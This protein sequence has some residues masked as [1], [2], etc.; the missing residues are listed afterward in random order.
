MTLSTQYRE[1]SAVREGASMGI[2]G[3]SHEGAKWK[4]ITIAE[5]RDYRDGSLLRRVEDHGNILVYGGASVLWEAFIG[6]GSTSTGSA[7]HFF[8]SKCALGIGNSSAAAVNTQKALQGGSKIFKIMSAGFPTHTTGST[9]AAAAQVQF[10]STFTTAQANFTWWEWGV[11]NI[12]TTAAVQ[13]LLNRKVANLLTKTS[14]ATA[15]LTVTL[16]LS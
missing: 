9:V 6:N 8:N 16:T 3:V 12:A 7:K 13:R 5:L 14:A 11:A 2:G 15:S 10:K 4:C 1:R